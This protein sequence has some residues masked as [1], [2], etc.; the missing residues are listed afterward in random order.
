MEGILFFSESITASEMAV[1]DL[2]N[3]I[4]CIPWLLVWAEI[5]FRGGKS[6]NA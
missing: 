6:N 5:K 2:E 1:S 3:L 4:R